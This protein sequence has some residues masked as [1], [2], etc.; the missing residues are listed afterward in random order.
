MFGK[1]QQQILELQNRVRELENI[2]VHLISMILLKQAGYMMVAILF[3][4]EK[5]GLYHMNVKD[6]T[7]RLLRQKFK[8]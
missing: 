4:Q 3:I 1:K 2:L 6:A 7:R 8:E 5:N